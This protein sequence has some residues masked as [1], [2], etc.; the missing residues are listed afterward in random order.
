M[1]LRLNEVFFLMALF[2][3][4][5]HGWLHNPLPRFSPLRAACSASVISSWRTITRPS[6]WPH[7]S[8]GTTPTTSRRCTGG[9]RPT[10]SWV[11]VCVCLSLSLAPFFCF[12]LLCQLQAHAPCILSILKHCALPHAHPFS[13]SLNLSNDARMSTLLFLSHL[14]CSCT[15]AL[16]LLSLSLSTISPRDRARRQATWTQQRRMC[17]VACP[18]ATMPSTST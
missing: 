14:S 11:S 16:T 9:P 18:A 5:S 10:C 6:A 7:W 13:L 17:V 4:S 2:A 15:R 8:S 1:L 12:L 3:L